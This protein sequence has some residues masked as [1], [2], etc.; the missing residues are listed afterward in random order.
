MTSVYSISYHYRAKKALRKIPHK[1]AQI[2]TG[3]TGD[4]LRENPYA[5]KA[6]KGRYRGLYS[7]RVRR[8]RA[9]Y[10]IDGDKLK[11]LILKIGERQGI[12]DDLY[13]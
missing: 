12:Y 1:D 5:G 13:F 11:I 9:I 7:L 4:S 8:F 3:K 2:I 10:R 6:L